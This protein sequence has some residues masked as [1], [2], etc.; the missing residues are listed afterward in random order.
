MPTN[1]TIEVTITIDTDPLPVRLSRLAREFAKR[2]DEAAT[3]A[4]GDTW[5]N[6]AAQLRLVAHL[7][8]SDTEDWSRIGWQWLNAA[9]AILEARSAS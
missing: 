6:E 8:E 7:C 1:D 9:Q 3:F 5:H 4:E 2:G